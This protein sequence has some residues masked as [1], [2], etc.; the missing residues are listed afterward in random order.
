MPKIVDH[1]T[2]REELARAMWEVIRRDGI[3][4]VSVRS[5]AAEAGVS[6]GSLRHYFPSQAE[7]IGFAMELVEVRTRERISRIDLSGTPMERVTALAE[8]VLPLDAERRE[9]LQV[10]YELTARARHDPALHSVSARAYDGLLDLARSVVGELHAAG[11][12]STPLDTER[13]AIT[14]HALLDGL[15][16]HLDQHPER[17]DV[18][19]VRAALRGYLADLAQRCG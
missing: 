1:E 7:L 10:W 8:E 11:D 16:V 19:T 14:L 9:D 6:A 4:R 12:P 15:A 3:D 2:R 17:L 5:V 13:E 18:A